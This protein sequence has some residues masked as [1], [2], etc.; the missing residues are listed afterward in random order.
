MADLRKAVE[1]MLADGVKHGGPGFWRHVSKVR[2]ALDEDHAP[3]PNGAG[4]DADKIAKAIALAACE[5]DDTP[6]PDDADTLT[7]TVQD[8]EAVAHRHITVALERAAAF[9]T[10][11]GTAR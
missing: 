5:L 8:V 4:I 6:D 3:Q 1:E 7:I 2:A 9:A 11:E 10:T